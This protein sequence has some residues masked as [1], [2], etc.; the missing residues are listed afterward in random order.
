MATEGLRKEGSHKTGEASQSTSSWLGQELAG[1]GCGLE[2]S[3]GSWGQLSW[4]SVVPSTLS[5]WWPVA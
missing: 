5:I 1:V 3:V 2:H 4:S